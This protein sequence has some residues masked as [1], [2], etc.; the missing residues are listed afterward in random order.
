MQRIAAGKR[1]PLLRGS[2]WDKKGALNRPLGA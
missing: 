1:F 2:R